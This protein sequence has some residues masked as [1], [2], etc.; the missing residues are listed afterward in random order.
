MLNETGPDAASRRKSGGLQQSGFRDFIGG[1][2][3][4]VQ[5]KL[6]KTSYTEKM[7]QMELK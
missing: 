2:L 3:E 4:H 5:E 1:R 7:L 6:L